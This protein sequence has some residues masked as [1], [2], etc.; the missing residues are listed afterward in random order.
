LDD[1]VQSGSEPVRF[2]RRTS[3]VGNCHELAALLWHWF[4][5]LAWHSELE[6]LKESPSTH[7][8]LTLLPFRDG[9][10]ISFFGHFSS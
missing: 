5:C 9:Y 1:V 10:T 8:G 7:F 6:I 4:G 2:R 3:A